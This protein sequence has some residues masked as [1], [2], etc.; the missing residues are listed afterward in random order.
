MFMHTQNQLVVAYFFPEC[1]RLKI[2]SGV[3]LCS[4]W[5]SVS[6]SKRGKVRLKSVIP[7]L[8][9]CV[10]MWACVWGWVWVA[11][12]QYNKFKAR[13]EWEEDTNVQTRFTRCGLSCIQTAAGSSVLYS[14]FL[15]KK[16]NL[17]EG[18]DGLDRDRQSKGGRVAENTHCCKALLMWSM[19][20]DLGAEGVVK[21]SVV[22]IL[23][24][25]HSLLVWVSLL[26][27]T[28]RE[29]HLWWVHKCVYCWA[30][31]GVLGGRVNTVEES[32]LAWIIHRSSHAQKCRAVFS[33][34]NALTLKAQIG[35]VRQLW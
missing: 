25:F 31:V 12:I 17:E 26:W 13:A 19:Q 33:L 20:T 18:W 4:M 28:P 16:I 23:S 6:M 2:L 22:F 35:H 30:S 8:C 10:R 5:V 14:G 32:G 21:W 1:R 34:G 24:A 27:A 15:K 7:Y 29:H 3:P 9:V 11:C